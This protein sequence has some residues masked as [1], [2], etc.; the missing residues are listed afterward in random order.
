MDDIK[1]KRFTD[2]PH[3]YQGYLEP[4]SG[5]WQLCIDKDGGP[6]LFIRIK[7]DPPQSDG[8]T[9][10]WLCVDDLLPDELCPADMILGTFGEEPSPEE[11]AEFEKERAEKNY[12]NRCPV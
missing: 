11:I 2:H 1:I 8:T 4:E 9:E 7:I 6:H 10:G 5:T 3:G 12:Q